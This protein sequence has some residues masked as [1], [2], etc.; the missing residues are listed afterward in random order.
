MTPEDRQLTGIFIWGVIASWE[1][2][3]FIWLVLAGHSN[4][5]VNDL[6]IASGVAFVLSIF[7]RITEEER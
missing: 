6:Y 3:I 5:S 4:S 7:A 2:V 1:L